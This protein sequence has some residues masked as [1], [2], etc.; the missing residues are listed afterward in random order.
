MK[1]VRFEGIE[2]I[3]KNTLSEDVDAHLNMT[4]T[5]TP[6]AQQLRMKSLE[7]SMITKDD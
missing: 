3:S 4:S 2:E 1:N 5:Q 7:S 6:S